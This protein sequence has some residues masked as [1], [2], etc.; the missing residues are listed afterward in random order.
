MSKTAILKTS[1]TKQ[2]LKLKAQR[3]I[4]GQL[5]ILS[6]ENNLDL[7]KVMEYPLGPVPWSLATADGMPIKTD[8]SALMT[9]L[10]EEAAYK[11]P[12]KESEHVHVI[13]GNALFHSLTQIPETFGEVAEQLFK[14]LPKVKRVHFLTD[15]YHDVSIKLTERQRRGESHAV[16]LS[17]PSM[18]TPKKDNWKEFLKNPDNKK[19][20]IP[21]ILTEWEKDDYAKKCT[22]EKFILH[23]TICAFF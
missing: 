2:E 7:Q 23:V 14:S 8:K 5:L 19:Q 9:K 13:D 4:F 21:F 17:G 16:S 20:F 1:K 18:R 3:N 22:I 11:H 6:E 15:N 12:K 10:E